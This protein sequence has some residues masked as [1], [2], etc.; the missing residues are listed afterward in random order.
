MK[1]ESHFDHMAVIATQVKI[2][3]GPSYEMI[4]EFHLGESVRMVYS[5][6]VNYP[7]VIL[8]KL[9]DLNLNPSTHESGYVEVF[10][11][12]LVA[13]GLF[14]VATLRIGVDEV[15]LVLIDGS[16]FSFAQLR[17]VHGARGF[18]INGDFGF[19]PEA[20]CDSLWFLRN[21]IGFRRN[22]TVHLRFAEYT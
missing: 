19:D 17:A 14:E 9:L 8:R 20:C 12:I 7:A 18:I 21:L 5:L 1:L 22:E 16:L 3:P 2:A 4:A 11:L 13:I 15:E 6:L 10:I